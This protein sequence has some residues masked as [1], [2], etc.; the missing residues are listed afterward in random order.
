MWKPTRLAHAALQAESAFKALQKCHVQ[1]DFFSI[2][3]ISLAM[4]PAFLGGGGKSQT[5]NKRQVLMQ[6]S[7]QQRARGFGVALRLGGWHPAGRPP[8]S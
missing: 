4:L 1:K 5:I 8:S 3:R 2:G 7:A 6:G